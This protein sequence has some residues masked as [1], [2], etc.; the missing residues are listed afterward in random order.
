MK[1]F[2]EH[3]RQCLTCFFPILTAFVSLSLNAP[4]LTSISSCRPDKICHMTS[5]ASHVTA[6]WPNYLHTAPRNTLLIV[7]SQ[8]GNEHLTARHTFGVLYLE[9][10]SNCTQPVLN[11]KFVLISRKTH[12]YSIVVWPRN[13]FLSLP[14][15]RAGRSLHGHSNFW[16]K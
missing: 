14:K 10:H 8:I 4:L 16:D 2:W 11:S 5:H 9:Y 1:P 7:S 13:Q 6:T 3:N 15:V 12:D